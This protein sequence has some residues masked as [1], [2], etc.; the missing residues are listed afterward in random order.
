MT[1]EFVDAVDVSEICDDID[2][3][4]IFDDEPGRYRARAFVEDKGQR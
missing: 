1:G 3:V 4:A 2:E